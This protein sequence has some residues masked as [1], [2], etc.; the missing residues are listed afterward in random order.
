MTDAGPMPLAEARALLRGSQAFVKGDFDLYR[1]I[2]V[3]PVRIEPRD[4][5]PYT[6][7][8][9]TELNQDFEL[10][11]KVTRLHGITD[12]Y[13]EILDIAE[14]GED[15]T[16]AVTCLVHMLRQAGRAVDPFRAAFH[17]RETTDGWR[18]FRV[19]SSLGHINWTLGQGGIED[20][21][22]T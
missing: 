16:V 21:S 18:L 4:G 9:E 2:M 7:E 22:F 19:Q 13:R 5:K 17:F 11:H 15:G 6:M 8:T 20:G 3:L 12:I 10:Y 1:Q 14:P